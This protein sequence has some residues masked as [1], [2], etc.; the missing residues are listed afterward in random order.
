MKNKSTSLESIRRRLRFS[1]S[2][3]VDPVGT[4]GGLAVWWTDDIDLDIRFKSSNLIRGV[5]SSPIAPSN[6]VAN[7]I[8]APSQR[9]V[10]RCFWV[11]FRSLMSDSNYLGLCIGDFN[12]IGAYSEKAGGAVCRMTQIHAFLELLSDCA[13]M[14]LEFNGP[15]FTRSNNQRG[16]LNIWERLDRA[17]ATA[18]WRTLY[19]YAQVF[20]DIQVGSDHCPLILNCILALKRVPWLFKFETMW[21]TSPECEEI[22]RKNWVDQFVGSPMFRLAK[23][24]RAC[25]EGLKVWSK[26]H[27]GNNK[28]QIA[29]IKSQLA[30]LQAQ[31]CFDEN[32]Q[33]QDQLKSALELVLSMEEISGSRDCSAAL[34]VVDSVVSS[35]MN[36][37]LTRPF[38][39]EEI[40][41][42]AFQL[43]AFKAPGP[44]GFP[45]FFYQ[46]YWDEV[47][48]SVCTA[49]RSFFNGGYILRELNQTNL[50]LIPKV[51]NR[52]LLSQ[53]RPIS[54][55]NFILKIITKLLPNRLKGILKSLISP[56]QSAFVSGRLIQDNVIVAHEAFHSLKLR[57]SGLVGQMAIKIDFDKAYD[58]IESDFLAMVLRKMGFDSQWVHWVMECV[59]TVSFSIFANGE[60]RAS[61]V[62]S[63]GLRQGDPLSP[64]L[65]IIVADVL[66]KLISHSLQNREI[67]GFKITRL[68][69]TLTHLF[70]AD[71]MLLFLK[72]EDTEYQKILDLLKVCCEASGQRVNF[73]KSSVQFSL[74]VAPAVCDSICALFGF[75]ISSSHAKYLGLPSFWGRSKSAAFEFIIEKV[76]SK[77]QGWKQ[78]LLSKAGREIL[79]KAVVQAIPSYAQKCLGKAK[80]AMACF[81]FPKHFCAKLNSYIS[82]FWWRGEP[83]HK[84]IHWISWGQLALPKFQGGLGFRDFQAFNSALL[85]RQGWRL[86][87]YP[88][89]FC[90]RILKGIYF[91]HTDFMH[92]SKGRRP[93]WGWAS[94]LQ[95]RQLLQQGI[96]WQINSS[97]PALFWEDCWIPGLPDFKVYSSKPIGTEVVTVEDVIDPLHKSWNLDLLRSQV[98]EPEVQAISSIPISLAPTEDSLI[99]HFEAKGQY[100]VKSGYHV[101]M[102]ASSGSSRHMPLSSFQV[103][104][105]FWKQIW[106]LK[107]PPKICHFWWRVCRNVLA[108]RENLFRRK[109]ASSSMCPLCHTAS[110]TVEHILFGCDWVR[111]VWFGS[112]INYKVDWGAIHSVLQWS[113]VMMDI[114]GNDEDRNSFFSLVAWIGWYIWKDRNNFVFNHI[115]VEPSSTLHRARVAMAEFEVGVYRWVMGLSRQPTQSAA[116]MDKWDPPQP[117]FFKVN[118][119]VAI[120]LGSSRAAAA[121]VLRDEH[122]RLVDGLTKKLCISSPFQGEAQ[123]CRLACLLAHQHNLL[124]VLVEGDNKAVIH[125]C[126]TETVPPWECVAILRDIKLLAP[127]GRFSFQWRPKASNKVAHWVARA[128]LHDQLPVNWVSNP[129]FPLFCLLTA[130]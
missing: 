25:R 26:E 76:I 79:I 14:D 36:Y 47:G 95:G 29:L 75:K 92:A 13:L 34:S 24:L 41:S 128:C 129:P 100:T 15:P 2:S 109:C 121:A 72:A 57:K 52:T 80:H 108:S 16:S 6:W 120:L 3:Y 93:S 8:H 74:N 17:V 103:P 30:N 102:M 125:L 122:G 9:A 127:Q 43:G 115:P 69:P 32:F 7:F 56:N 63:R 54:L 87:K 38:C 48:G 33:L 61:F 104:S 86:V 89:S 119:D 60:K 40:K 42:A 68:C 66:S 117:G 90:A 35:D 123:A 118:C 12:E 20:H 27:F 22:I 67:S 55:C 111:P 53:F 106:R 116:A 71:D 10:R 101:A 73:N 110:E 23:K 78:K 59:S 112:A 85:A 28:I 31:P 105:S 96:R 88:N 58:R 98:S 82:N 113:S 107:V 99:W 65:F 5:I 94:L 64:Y 124:D 45:G 114:L 83:D 50:V 81:A 97:S 39:D 70:F 11:Q 130:S 84:G 49:V 1:H 91:P 21:S 4:S 46:N 44:D 126:V 19:P 62:P 51:S 77:F 37:D 18:D